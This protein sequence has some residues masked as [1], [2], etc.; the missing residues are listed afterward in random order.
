[1][2]LDPKGPSDACFIET[3]LY[4]RLIS[5]IQRNIT[6]EHYYGHAHKAGILPERLKLTKMYVEKN[7]SQG[8]VKLQGRVQF[9]NSDSG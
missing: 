1:M 4:P 9:N 6:V 5:V 3:N 8:L 2:I 7:I